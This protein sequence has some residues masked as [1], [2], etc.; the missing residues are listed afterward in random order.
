EAYGVIT[1]FLAQKHLTPNNLT[2]LIKVDTMLERKD[3]MSEFADGFITMPGGFGT[4]D[5]LFETLT[6]AQLG[7][8]KKP[9]GILNIN[10]FYDSLFTLL[11]N[12]VKEKLLLEPHR[13][14]LI[15]SESPEKLISMMNNYKAPKVGKWIDKI[16]EEN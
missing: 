4:M 7:F 13:K 8:T 15:S 11:D 10:G 6:A 14:M 5:E 1:E 3:K 12:M 9:I 2:K 16:I